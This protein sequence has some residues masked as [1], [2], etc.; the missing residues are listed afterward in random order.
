MGIYQGVRKENWRRYLKEIEF[1]YNNR[2]ISYRD[3]VAV[4]VDILMGENPG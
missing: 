2:E 1:K 4:L 3:Q